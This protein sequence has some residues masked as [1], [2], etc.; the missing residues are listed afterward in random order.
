MCSVTPC[1]CSSLTL[2][3]KCEGGLKGVCVLFVGSSGAAAGVSCKKGST[4]TMS[5]IAHTLHTQHARSTLFNAA[6]ASTGCT[7]HHSPEEWG[8]DVPAELVVDEDLPAV[9]P[10]LARGGGG[11]GGSRPAAVGGIEVDE[12][13]ERACM[14]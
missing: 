8:D 2:K 1:F 14:G 13:E 12:L 10:P 5:I 7:R 11:G 6:H 9:A 3:E 4:R